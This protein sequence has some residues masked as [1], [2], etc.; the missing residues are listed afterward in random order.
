MEYAGVGQKEKYI[1]KRPA[2]GAELTRLISGYKGIIAARLHTNIV[3]FSTGC[4]S[5][6]LVWNE[7]LVQWGEG[8]GYPERFIRAENMR[9]QAVVRSLLKAMEE[10][11]EICD[12]VEKNKIL[13]PLCG[14]LKKYGSDAR[15]KVTDEEKTDWEN[16]LVATALGGKNNQFAGMNSPDTIMESYKNG[17]RLFEVDLKLTSDGRLVCANGWTEGT[18]RKLGW[19]KERGKGFHCGIEYEQFIK[20]KYYNGHYRTMDWEMLVGYVDKMKDSRFI[21]DIRN[22]TNGQMQKLKMMIKRDLDNLG[23]LQQR[24]ILKVMKREELEAVRD[25]GME[26]MY[27]IPTET[28]MEETGS[29]VAEIQSLCRDRDL[30]WISIRNRLCSTALIAKLKTPGRKI[31]VSPCNQVSEI[32]KWLSAGADMLGTDY[33]S[34]CKLE[35]LLG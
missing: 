8:I 20:A 10:G 13:A 12:P 5:I 18:F 11:C 22:H 33:Q 3:A 24:L 21:L 16:I 31:F 23:I 25:M 27:E 15:G 28:E 1:Q 34:V 26:I 7:K 30:S 14:F 6:G 32:V 17:F 4:P 29:N 2:E 9:P 19:D 35:A